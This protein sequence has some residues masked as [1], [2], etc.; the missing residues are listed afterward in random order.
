MRRITTER[1]LELANEKQTLL[2]E[3]ER[4]RH[5]DLD[6]AAADL[7]ERFLKQ[8]ESL[9]EASEDRDKL[10]QEEIDALHEQIADLQR[11]AGE[12]GDEHEAEMKEAQ[13]RLE[14]VSQMERERERL[15]KEENNLGK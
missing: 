14:I 1:Q 4:A 12:R 13:R 10:A 11:I 6:E 8:F 15:A 9:R 2:A 3:L 7:G 5:G